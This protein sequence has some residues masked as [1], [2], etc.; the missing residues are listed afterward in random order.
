MDI[1]TT[2][3]AVRFREIADP[4]LHRDPLRHTVIA[5][6][7][8][9]IT[10]GLDNPKLPPVFVSARNGSGV[11][12][13]A[14]RAG[15]RDI[16]LGALSPDVIPA[17]TE[18]FAGSSPEAAGVE[19]L[20]AVAAAFAERWCEIR[21]GDCGPSFSTTLYRLGELAAPIVPGFARQAR[22]AD[23]DLCMSWMTAMRVNT[24]IPAGPPSAD[25]VRHRILAGS[26]WLWEVDGEPVSLVARQL[27]SFGWARIGP[28]FTPAVAR[29]NGYAS[30]LTAHV[31][32]VIRAESVDVCLFADTDNEL[33]NRL[34]R[35]LGFVPVDNYTAYE[36]RKPVGAGADRWV[37]EVKVR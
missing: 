32:Q 34:Y 29:G 27:A 30:A 18:A 8:N 37:P 2:G 4:V 22:E 21:G 24:G 17:V 36:F 6:T 5:T 26:W 10:S 25:A 28:V 7:V 3:D 14:M 23:V 35:G 31:S 1:E 11:T 15:H 13:I 19:G 12:G 33:T 20:T 16:Y 9:N